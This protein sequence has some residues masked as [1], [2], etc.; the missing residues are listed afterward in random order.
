MLVLKRPEFENDDYLLRL[1][2]DEIPT[3]QRAV[4]SLKGFDPVLADYY[5]VKRQAF[6]EK[7]TDPQVFLPFVGSRPSLRALTQLRKLESTVYTVAC[8]K[9]NGLKHGE[10]IKCV[11][12]HLQEK[13]DTR[14]CVVRFANSFDDYLYSELYNPA[15]VTCLNLIHYLKD[16]V[17]LVFRASDVKNEL[18]VDLLTI[19]EFF[20]EPVYGALDV[21][22][23]VYASTAQGVEYWDK[24]VKMVKNNGEENT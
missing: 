22:L 15:D 16:G 23:S 2:L 14:R 18:F 8:E 6:L 5:V 11:K 7:N 19:K 4:D 3:G 20:L 1:S 12:L 9:A 21:Q 10:I 13:P 24:F 17:K